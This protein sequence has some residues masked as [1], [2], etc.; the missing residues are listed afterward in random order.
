MHKYIEWIVNV[1]GDSN[2]GYQ[3]VSTLLGKGEDNYTL[4]R[5]QLIHELGIH[6]ESYI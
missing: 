5:Q 3:A 2:Y 4:V 1:K 6:K